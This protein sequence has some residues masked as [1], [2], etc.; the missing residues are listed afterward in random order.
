MY[1]TSRSSLPFPAG[2]DWKLIVYHQ[3]TCKQI[4]KKQFQLLSFTRVVAHSIRNNY[5]TEHFY[6]TKIIR[7][8]SRGNVSVER[9][10]INNGQINYLF[11][12]LSHVIS[13]SGVLKTETT[14]NGNRNN[15]KIPKAK[16]HM[17]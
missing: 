13:S 11:L 14:A 10:H 3:S 5:D 16:Q 4:K 15:N 12:R 9:P 7:Y 8:N 6:N 2:E 17:G 1:Y